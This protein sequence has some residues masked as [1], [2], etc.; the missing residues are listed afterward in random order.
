MNRE[1]LIELMARAI[2][3]R[4]P[5]RYWNH[6]TDD[7]SE[8]SFDEV[9]A[10]WRGLAIWCAGDA[11]AAIEAAGVKLETVERADLE[12]AARY[13]VAYSHGFRAGWNAGVDNDNRTSDNIEARQAEA[14]RVLRGIAAAPD[15]LGEKT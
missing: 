3:A 6:A 9:D 14:Q 11:L 1:E 7:F 15:A 8:P 2:Y 5:H 4:R 10:G 13:D 12:K